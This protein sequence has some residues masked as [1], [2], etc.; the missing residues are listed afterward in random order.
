MIQKIFLR[1]KI[2][3]LLSILILSSYMSFAQIERIPSKKADSLGS[4]RGRKDMIKDLDLTSGQMAKLKEIRQTGRM[5]KQAINNNDQLTDDEKKKQLRQLQK[6]QAKNILD[7]L[8]D[9]QK[10]KLKA[11]RKQNK[12]M[13]D[14]KIN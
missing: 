10:E 1:M 14:E 12:E 5:K 6:E 3:V 13:E 4:M 7:I 9:E 11:K 8:T 2:P